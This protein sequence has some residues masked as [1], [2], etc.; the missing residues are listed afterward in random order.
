M[1]RRSPATTIL[2]ALALGACSFHASCGG[3]KLDTKKG[4]TAIGKMLEDASGGLHAKVTCP[5][6]VELKKDVVCE[7]TTEM[8][9]VPG[10][11]KVTQTDDDGNV[12]FD[13]VEGYV[14]GAKLE[15]LIV[16]RLKQ[17]TGVDGK[18][19]CGDRV[20]ASK[21]D[22]TFRCTAHAPNGDTLAVD[23]KITDTQG[24]VDLKFSQPDAA[25]PPPS[26]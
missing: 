15:Q 1:K 8:E 10:R 5:T 2:F 6:D 25:P 20:R 26:P 22:S 18:V 17:Q 23:I 16:D 21:P 9:G 12:H 24:N 3:K 14:F 7:C 4:E 11:V 13:M 19:E